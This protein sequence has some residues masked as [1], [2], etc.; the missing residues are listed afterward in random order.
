MI[1]PPQC[2]EV[3]TR[4]HPR[5]AILHGGP[6]TPTPS[7]PEGAALVWT[8]GKTGED[9]I[10]RMQSFVAMMSRETLL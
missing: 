4:A 5:C 9:A 7:D 3:D 2:V 6:P 8:Y 10:A 1:L